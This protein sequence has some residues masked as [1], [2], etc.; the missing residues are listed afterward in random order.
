MMKW[1]VVRLRIF[2]VV[3]FVDMKE[4]QNCEFE[5]VDIYT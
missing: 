2:E 1:L 5:E 3:V 4:E